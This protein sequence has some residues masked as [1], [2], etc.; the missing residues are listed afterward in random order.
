[1]NEN[2]LRFAN[3]KKIKFLVYDFETCGLNLGSLDNKCWQA[4]FL[5]ADTKDIKKEFDLFPFW[6]NLKM[7]AEAARITRFNFDNYKSKSCDA[8]KALDEFEQYLYDPNVI[9]VG[10]NSL[11]FD[12]MIHNIW[13][14][15]LGKKSDYSYLDRHIDTSCVAKGYKM[16]NSF[17]G[18]RIL[19]GEKVGSKDFLSWQFRLANHRDR[20]IKSNLKVLCGDFGID[21]DP[22]KHHDA[23]WDV[24]MTYEILK[25]LYWNM[26][27]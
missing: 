6:K 13:R 11:R 16:D 8:Q 1:M 24:R 12:T 5:I 18:E 25:R 27:I 17:S 4:S 15:N 26:E 3:P 14:S 23:L 2:L 19:D 9:S 7:G 20:K 22:S 10:Q 21:Y